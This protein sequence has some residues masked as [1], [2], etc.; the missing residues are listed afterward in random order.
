MLTPKQEKFADLYVELGN[1]SEAYRQSYDA[2]K[3][4]NNAIAGKANVLLNN[5]K[6]KVYIGGIKAK[7]ARKSMIT[8]ESILSDLKDIVDDYKEFKEFAKD[9]SNVSQMRKAEV[10]ASYASS[11]SAIAALKQISKMCGFDA[12]EKIEVDHNV[13]ININK[14]KD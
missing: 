10:L 7:L 11:P 3:M 4:G 5:E 6:V 9:P 2:G 13:V 14:P 12:P 1:A 8:K